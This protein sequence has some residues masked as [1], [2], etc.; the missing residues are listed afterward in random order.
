[1]TFSA[2]VPDLV[3]QRIL[4]HADVSATATYYIMT[5]AVDIRSAMTK[6][7]NR[8]EETG[9]L[10]PTLAGRRKPFLGPVPQL[11]IKS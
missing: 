6:L 4:S 5:A 11:F 3:I 8:I 10:N 9:G 2:G 7:E 1:M